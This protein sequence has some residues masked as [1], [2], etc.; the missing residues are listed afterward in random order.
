MSLC[1]SCNLCCDGTIFT[2]VDLAPAEQALFRKEELCDVEGGRIALAQRCSQLGTGGACGIYHNRP[3]KCRT[4]DCALL[5]RVERG[6]TAMDLAELIVTETKA[7]AMRSHRLFDQLMP[8]S[9]GKEKSLRLRMIALDE[10]FQRAEVPEPAFALA[11]KAF[12]FVRLLVDD[13][14]K[15]DPPTPE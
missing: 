10:A 3:Q 13:H 5:S 12:L 14:F 6:E 7:A 11:Q 1:L 9:G 15:P 8:P 4:F 2:H